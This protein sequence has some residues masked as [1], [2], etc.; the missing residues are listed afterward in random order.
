MT[1][2]EHV[3][4]AILTRFKDRN[5][6]V[7]LSSPEVEIF[8]EVRRDQSF[9]F[10]ESFKGPGGLPMGTQGKIMGIFNDERS[11]IA[12]WLM[13]KRG[14]RVYPIY[15]KAKE[16]NQS[17]DENQIVA[18]V[19]VLKRWATNIYLKIINV[20]S[21]SIDLDNKEFIEYTHKVKAK[22][23]CLSN[24]LES[25]F[26]AGTKYNNDLPV[27]YPLIGLDEKKINEIKRTIIEH[28]KVNNNY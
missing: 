7:N 5:L 6:K 1:L 13:M 3:G 27:F 19:K 15:F 4:E 11:Y 20:D 22:G 12:T 28:V 17:I 21:K 16:R 18:Q 26:F 24:N 8:I 10:S 25:I 9:I 23:I 2:A 14:C